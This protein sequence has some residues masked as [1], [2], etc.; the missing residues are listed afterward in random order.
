MNIREL[1]DHIRSGPAELVLDKPLRFRRRTRSN[2]CDFNEFLQALQSSET[3]RNVTCKQHICPDDE[4]VLLVKTI[5]LITNIQNLNINCPFGSRE[6]HP[7]QAVAD[8]VKNAHSLCELRITVDWGSFPRGSSELIAL[9]NAIQEHTTLQKFLWSDFGSH[10]QP[11]AVP[12][13]ALDPVFL[14]L[15]TCHHLREVII[16]A[17]CI[18]A[19]IMTLLHMQS[20]LALVLE[21]ESWLAVADEIRR[22]RCNVKR[23][24]L[25]LVKVTRSE[26]TEA[27]QAVASAIQMDN[28]IESLALRM[29]TGYTDEAGVALAEALTVNTTLKS[30]DLYTT[31]TQ[32][33]NIDSLG[34]P[35]Y[36]ALSAM[37]VKKRLV[38]K[39]PTFK[40]AGADE[41]LCESRDQ[42]L[43]EMRLNEVGRGILLSS[44]FTTRDMWVYS[45][46]ALNSKNMDESPAFQVSCLYSILLSHPFV[47]MT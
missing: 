45:L 29:I 31:G 43:I 47:C 4:W 7:L 2:P 16:N 32:E 44:T 18:G 20:T 12:C 24:V 21:K 35:A 22:G 36:E 37:L 5:G 26:G 3:I 46:C 25:D 15:Q 10:V 33:H 6:F 1:V 30:L 9:A 28:N 13:A 14:A 23:L 27:L 39:L 8:G 42:L 38:L 11:G 40:T 41:K 34:V 17:T 19:G